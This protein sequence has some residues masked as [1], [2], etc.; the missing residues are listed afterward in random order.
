MKRINIA[1]GAPWEPVVGYSRAVRVGDVVHV[2]G[3]TAT[4]AS[5]QIVGAG[6][7]YAQTVQALR[8]IERALVR[9]GATL[10]DVVRTRVYVLNIQDWERIGRA[11]GEFFGAIRPA[12]T[13]VQVSG[14]VDPAMLVEIEAEAVIGAR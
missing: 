14:L 12:S 10:Q 5:G 7:P 4:D 2:A 1:S 13:M 3:T 9:A 8:N 11:H 6:D